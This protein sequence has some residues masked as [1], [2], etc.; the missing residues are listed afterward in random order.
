MAN[1]QHSAIL[2]AYAQNTFGMTGCQG[3]IKLP[4]M[5]LLWERLNTILRKAAYLF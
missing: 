1:N 4:V 2:I 5:F 3:L